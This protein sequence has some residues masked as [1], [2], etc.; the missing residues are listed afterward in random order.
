MP[1]KIGELKGRLRKA[2]LSKPSGN[3]SRKLR[4]ILKMSTITADTSVQQ[5][6]AQL[7][8]VTEIR[9]A[10]G[11]VFGIFTPQELAEEEL[12]YERAERLFDPVEMKRRLR[13][14]QGTAVPFEEVLKRIKAREKK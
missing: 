8:E 10:Q 11:N 9:D 5:W 12:L 6:L 4:E 7:K 3:E 2:A 14:E 1:K 13:E